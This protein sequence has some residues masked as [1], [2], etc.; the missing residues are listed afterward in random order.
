MTRVPATH[1]H[2]HV[3]SHDGCLLAA[4]HY[5]GSLAGRTRGTV[6]IRTPYGR[7]RYRAQAGSWQ[8]AGFDVVVQDVRGRYGS[9]GEWHPYLA[10]GRDGAITAHEL[11]RRR[12][13]R[14]PL[15]LA[16]ASYDA[17]C[18]LEAARDLEIRPGGLR[19]HAVVAMVPALGLYETAREPGGHPRYLD[20]IG[21]WHQHGFGRVSVPGLPSAE[22]QRLCR[23]ARE[24][25]PESV[26]SDA[27]HGTGAEA[28]WHRLWQAGPLEF[29]RRYGLLATPL[30]V[31]SGRRDFFA[32][33]A[34]RLAES[35]SG[36]RTG[37]LWGPWGHR[38]GAD[39]D[40]ARA[41]ALKE[42]GGLLGRIRSWLDGLQGD[43]LQGDGHVS[44]PGAGPSTRE[45]AEGPDGNCTWRPVRRDTLL[46]GTEPPRL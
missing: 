33:E 11:A 26:I 35:W 9:D 13:L 22:L 32:A 28:K 29:D 41:R 23:Q 45:F 46:H 18:A 38:L 25:G 31:V 30:L 27:V 1:G 44:E 20:R 40:A 16:G 43:G 21:W 7:A 15:I 12:L 2:L 39:L 8:R 19:A 34:I 4:D 3:R 36:G 5:T 37:L 14:G 24:L 6:L 17:H 42:N 10:E